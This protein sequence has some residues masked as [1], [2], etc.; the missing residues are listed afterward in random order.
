MHS[1]YG[2]YFGA[3]VMTLALLLLASPTLLAGQ[4]EPSKD[5]VAVV[6]GVEISRTD[7]DAEISRARQRFARPGQPISGTRLSEIKKDVLESLI[8]RELLYQTSQ[9]HGIK[10]DQAEINNQLAML[11]KRFPSEAEFN[12]VLSK[13][14]LS[15]AAIKAQLERNMAIKEFIDKQFVQK[16]TISDK[17]SKAYYESNPEYFKQPEQVQAR[18]ILI[19]IGSKADESQ[20]AQARKKI[21]KIRKRLQ[22][23]E[24]FAAL[25]KEFSQCP[26]KAKGGDL[27]YFQHGQM[28]PAFEQVA[29]ALK[30]G[31][32][33]DIVETRFGYHL[34]KVIGKKPETTIPYKD[35]KDK[36]QQHLKREKIQKEV[37]LYVEKLKEKAKVER[38]STDDF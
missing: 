9:K 25:A 34:I 28:A 31:A 14:N 2:R 19:K 30:P 1:E 26:S 24:D 35:V 8:G 7:F 11:K 6:N 32:V 12:K 36:L 13:N 16:V 27:G 3:L 15:E 33:S 10:V 29:F 20:K 37:T 21:E 23:G 38:F 17:K 18:H 5:T 4:K 22:K